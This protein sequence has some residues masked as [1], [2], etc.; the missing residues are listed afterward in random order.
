[1]VLTAPAL[2][3]MVVSGMSASEIDQMDLPDLIGWYQ[4]LEQYHKE[5]KKDHG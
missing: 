1:M 4:I 5:V 3:A 2:G